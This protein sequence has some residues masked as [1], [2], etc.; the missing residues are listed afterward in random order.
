MKAYI[1]LIAVASC[2]MA[3]SSYG[4]ETCGSTNG[5]NVASCACDCPCAQKTA[6]QQNPKDDGQK[7]QKDDG[8]KNPQGGDK[9]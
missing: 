4:G 8:Q 3:V 1:G 9:K 6:G 7:N 5:T 2:W